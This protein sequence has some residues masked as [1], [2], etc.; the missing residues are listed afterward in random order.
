MKHG[1]LYMKIRLFEN[2]VMRELLYLVY[3]LTKLFQRKGLA[4]QH[5]KVNARRLLELCMI[6]GNKKEF[7]IITGSHLLPLTIS[8]YLNTV[9]IFGLQTVAIEFQEEE[10][11]TDFLFNHVSMR[12]GAEAVFYTTQ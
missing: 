6:C 10:M 1:N 12:D 3:F 2:N 5:E 4:L 7:Y 9:A 8:Q 11:S